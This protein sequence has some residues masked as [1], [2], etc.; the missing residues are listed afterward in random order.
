[1]K[2]RPPFRRRLGW[3]I[4]LF[5]LLWGCAS[6]KDVAPVVDPSV[7]ASDSRPVLVFVPGIT[8]S[9]LRERE[10]GTV[11]WGEGRNLISPRDGGYGLARSILPDAANRLEAFDVIDEMRLAT[12]RKPIYGPVRD[13]FVANGY[14]PGDIEAPTADATLYLFPYDWRQD[15]VASA[16]QLLARL[17]AIRAARGSGALRVDLVCQSNGA[18]ICR[19]LIK[20]G[21]ASLDAVEANTST[22]PAG[23]AFERMIF[24]GAA[25]GGSIRILR[26]IDRGRRY[27]PLAGRHLKP[28]TLFTFPSLYQDLPAY[29]DDLFLDVIGRPMSVDLYDPESWRRYGWSVFRPEVAK[30]LTRVDR[31]DLFGNEQER[32][33]FL[34]RSLA[35]ARRFQAALARDVPGFVPPRYHQI[36]NRS[37]PTPERAVL[38]ARGASWKTLF[39]GD[40]GIRGAALIAAASS[41]GDGHAT[42]ASQRWLAPQ[43]RAA[44]ADSTPDGAFFVDGK[45]FEMILE[46]A[47]HD[48]LL[49]ILRPE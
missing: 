21:G 44:L 46:P 26:E 31:A 35:R 45:H 37:K 49:E 2:P 22:P 28:E 8:G 16:R 33:A 24:V 3:L 41:E 1:M 11:L 18:H 20:Y 36:Q 7:L 29:R 34:E 40:R 43:E 12:I 5:V 25:N 14:R 47:T 48:R 15:N 42:L 27:V 13:L 4:T 10:S 19:Y 38:V 32:M 17:E 6:S 9:K 23:I 30:R 39:V